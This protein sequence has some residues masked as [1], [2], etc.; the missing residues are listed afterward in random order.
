LALLRIA[1]TDGSATTCRC[2]RALA[3]RPPH[4]DYKK[5]L[6]TPRLQRFR[7]TLEQLVPRQPCLLEYP[8]TPKVPTAC[9]PGSAKGCSQSVRPPAHRLL[10]AGS[11]RVPCACGIGWLHGRTDA[12]GLGR[13]PALDPIALR[14]L[15]RCRW[16]THAG[17]RGNPR[18]STSPPLSFLP[19]APNWPRRGRS[20]VAAV[21]A[22]QLGAR[23][24]SER[25]PAQGRAR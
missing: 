3:R 10:S 21:G 16:G 14:P 11:L 7:E 1:G 25:R 20:V 22:V 24:R 4:G 17:N 5:Q 6:E 2:D 18:R 13:L 9:A 8:S 23:Q 15:P 19:A 12:D